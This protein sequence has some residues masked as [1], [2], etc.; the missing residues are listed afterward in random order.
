MVEKVQLTQ[1]CPESFLGGGQMRS[2]GNSMLIATP[3]NNKKSAKR[4][5]ANKANVMT[6]N[7]KEYEK[8]LSS[9]RGFFEAG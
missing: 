4:A 1:N 2:F 3:K 8:Y 6:L 9:L 5:N 7:E